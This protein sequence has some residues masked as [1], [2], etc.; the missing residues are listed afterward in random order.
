MSTPAKLTKTTL[1][2]EGGQLIG[3]GEIA[4]PN[5][6]FMMQEFNSFG[7]SGT[8]ELPMRSLQAMEAQVKVAA[9]NARFFASGLNVN[10]SFRLQARATFQTVDPVSG[11]A[12][13]A[14][15]VE[16]LLVPKAFDLGSRNQSEG[17]EFNGTFSV[18][19]VGYFSN[20]VEI[21]FA[22]PIN[23][24]YRVNGVDLFAADRVALGL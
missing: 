21:M 3:Q 8:V 17:G 4:L 19:S 2:F 16:L 24:V 10:A 22:D 6:Q 18:L 9:P 20:G 14:E 7:T 11:S 1:F 15:R 23:N 5:I 13:V 12:I